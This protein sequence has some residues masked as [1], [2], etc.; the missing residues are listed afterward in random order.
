MIGSALNAIQGMFPVQ[1][2]RHSFL[3]TKISFPGAKKWAKESLF[4][5]QKAEDNL[6]ESAD[7]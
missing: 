2:N 7:V 5:N 6:C 3:F 4:K 1:S